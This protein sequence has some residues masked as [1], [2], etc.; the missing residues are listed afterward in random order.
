MGQRYGRDFES[1]AG[2]NASNQPGLHALD[3]TCRQVLK[4]SGAA[5]AMLIDSHIQGR[6]GRKRC[7]RDF[8]YTADMAM[9]AADPRLEYVALTRAMK[10]MYPNV[11]R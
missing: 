4:C 10:N 5:I 9:I 2:V 3:I 8:I 11:R 7:T 1:G 6:R